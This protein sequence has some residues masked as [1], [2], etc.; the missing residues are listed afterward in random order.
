MRHSIRT[1]PSGL[2]VRKLRHWKQRFDPNAAFVWRKRTR[3]RGEQYEAGSLLEEGLLHRTKLRR[4]W[5]AQRIELAYFEDPNVLTGKVEVPS[6][7]PDGVKVEKH[8][9]GWYT[10]IKGDQKIKV[11]GEANLKAE[12]AGM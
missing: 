7:L 8:G 9:V 12:L 4:F 1:L 3:F 10:I 2:R 11:R 5:E 6:D